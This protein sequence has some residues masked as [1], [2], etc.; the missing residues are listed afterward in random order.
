MYFLHKSGNKCK[1]IITLFGKK[2]YFGRYP[3]DETIKRRDFLLSFFNDINA[4]IIE[5]HTNK[6]NI[7]FTDKVIIQ[8]IIHI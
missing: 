4:E 1:V 2:H 3:E 5:F 6:V 8:K 7:Y